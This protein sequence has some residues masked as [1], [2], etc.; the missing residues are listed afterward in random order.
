MAHIYPYW[1]CG[2]GALDR[3]LNFACTG[4]G[5]YSPMGIGAQKSRWRFGL[6][7]LPATRRYFL[8]E[9]PTHRRWRML[10][11][12]CEPSILFNE[13]TDGT[14]I[15]AHVCDFVAYL[16]PVGTFAKVPTGLRQ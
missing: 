6:E 3:H 15:I 11:I 5:Y 8:T 9:V 13:S 10:A 14:G 7:A 4:S 12:T 16:R 2:G 1:G